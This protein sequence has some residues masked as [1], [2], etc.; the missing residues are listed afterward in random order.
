[1]KILILIFNVL[2]F[3][4][5]ARSQ[6]LTVQEIVGKMERNEKISSIESTA[7]QTITTSKGKKRI[8][9]MKSFSK[10]ENEKQLT[11][12]TSPKRV[13]GD[14]ILM[15][16]DGDDI[17]FYTPKTD[18]VRHLASHAKKRKVQGS[19][20]S[21]QDI[22]NWD[23]EKDFSLK[24]LGYENIEDVNCFKI[25]MIPTKTGPDYS[26]MIIWVD[27]EK[28]FMLRADYYE[29]DEILKR[30]T[31]LNLEKLDKHWIAKKMLMKNLQDGG[32]T[33]IETISI[34]INVDLK[35]RM[36]TTNFLK[37]N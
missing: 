34:K 28:F 24:I 12:Y 33:L 20:F 27:K 10:N 2:F 13:K 35:D 30:L 29:D 4:F 19:D 18:R 11:I 17:W 36:F 9:E 16:N 21:Y 15:L 14:K 32:E 6:S 22:Q 23:Y 31:I 8:L 26:K 37:K 7:K 5:L 1:M 3:T 25:E